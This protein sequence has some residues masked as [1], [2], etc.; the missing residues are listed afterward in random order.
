[1]TCKQPTV[2]SQGTDITEHVFHESE[3]VKWKSVC[4]KLNTTPLYHQTGT[5]LMHGL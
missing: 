3:S 2:T 1:M 4:S 5:T